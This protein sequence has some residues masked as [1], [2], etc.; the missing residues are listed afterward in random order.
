M[1]MKSQKEFKICK[2]ILRK[3][4]TGLALAAVTAA[5]VVMAPPALACAFHVTPIEMV[6]MYTTSGTPVYAAPDV[7][8]PVVV[9][10][11]R[12]TN[13]RVYGITDNGFFQVDLNGTFYIPGPF[14]VSRI[15]PEKTEKQKALD[16]LEDFTAAYRTQLEYMESYSE[17]FALIDVTGDGVPEI[18][19]D[20]GREI[21]TYYGERPVMM[22]YSENPVTFYY[23]KKDNILLGKYTWN[24]KDIWEVYSKDVSLLPWGQFKCISTYASPYTGNATAVSREYVNNAETRADLYNILK[25]ILSL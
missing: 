9:Y 5:V 23:S 20:A 7:F 25:K 16:D 10:L 6:E 13:V 15:E 4:K 22:Y 3:L 12:F 2:P 1:A 14:M 11:D 21:Y 17:K 19:D 8:S 24:K 18:F